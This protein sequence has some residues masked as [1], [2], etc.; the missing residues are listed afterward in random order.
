VKKNPAEEPPLR[1]FKEGLGDAEVAA[2]L[3]IGPNFAWAIRASSGLRPVAERQLEIA[4]AIV[5]RKRAAEAAPKTIATSTK[6]AA[7]RRVRRRSK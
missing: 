3:G 7:K 6:T 2:K 5:A 1:L 4:R